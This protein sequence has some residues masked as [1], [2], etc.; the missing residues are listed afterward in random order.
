M[1]KFLLILLILNAVYAYTCD[2]LISKYNAPDPEYKTMKQIKRWFESNLE[3]IE[4]EDKDALLECLIEN[5]ADNPN[6]ETIAGE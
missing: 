6:R 5:A 4:Q 3:K 1:K 2:G